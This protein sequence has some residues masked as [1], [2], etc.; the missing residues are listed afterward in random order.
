[1][2]PINVNTFKPECNDNHLPTPYIVGQCHLSRIEQGVTR[3]LSF[4]K[5][6]LNPPTDI[7][8]CPLHRT[9]CFTYKLSLAMSLKT[10]QWNT[11][12]VRFLHGPRTYVCKLFMWLSDDFHGCV[13]SNAP[14]GSWECHAESPVLWVPSKLRGDRQNLATFGCS[15]SNDECKQPRVY[16]HPRCVV[17]VEIAEHWVKMAPRHIL[18]VGRLPTSK[19]RKEGP[20]EAGIL[21]GIRTSSRC[22]RV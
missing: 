3:K 15:H 5:T 11:S 16:W 17:Q 9:Q 21:R 18:R 4:Q 6:Y 19:I 14:R 1:M 13:G 2:G 7:I 12:K 22:W 10:Q 20:Y 8:H